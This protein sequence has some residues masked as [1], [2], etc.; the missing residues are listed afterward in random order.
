MADNENKI[1]LNVPGQANVDPSE[2][3]QESQAFKDPLSGRDTDT[4]SLAKL[5]DTRTRK[6]VKIKASSNTGPV[7]VIN[8]GSQAAVNPRVSTESGRV[9]TE[10][11]R[12]SDVLAGR[13][14]D[15]GN[16]ERMDD[17]KTRK[18][19][20]L[21]P[22]TASGPVPVIKLNTGSAPISTES[23]PISPE[24]TRTR[25]TV[26]LK[27][28]PGQ[29]VPSY[30]T[31]SA[32]LSDVLA[33]RDTDTGN[34]E[35]MDD[36]KTRKT[37]KLTP[38]TAAGTIPKVTPL[39]KPPVPGAPPQNFA[40]TVELKPVV[41]PVPGKT[42]P[43]IPTDT[44]SL[45]GVLEDTS[46]RK[47][48]KISPPPST[49]PI[50]LGTP[51]ESKPAAIPNAEAGVS[52]DTGS[53][54]GVI[55]DTATRKSVKI[56]P[57]PASAAP[58]QNFAATVELKPVVIPVPG[59]AEA[60]VSTDTGSLRGVLEDTSTRKTVKI[61][62]LPT[63]AAPPVVPAGLAQTVVSPTAPR[64]A[65]AAPD[66]APMPSRDNDDTVRLQKAKI[67]TVPPPGET[68]SPLPSV[69]QAKSVVP[70]S[71]QTI[72][73]RPSTGASTPPEEPAA[74]AIKLSPAATTSKD[75]I[76]LTPVSAA[77]SAPAP[78]APTV[79]L[80][81]SSTPP[82]APAAGAVA[83]A[84][85]VN[86]GL[87]PPAGLAPSSPTVNLSAPSAPSGLSLKKPAL[88]PAAPA[89]APKAGLSLPGKGP[90]VKPPEP[91]A[92]EEPQVIEEAAEP[93]EEAVEEK[94]AGGLQIKKR[95]ADEETQGPP[96]VQTDLEKIENGP[97]VAAGQ[98]SMLYFALAL[99]SVI[100]LLLSVY[101]TAA[102][103][104]NLWEQGRMKT[105]L[106]VPFLSEIVK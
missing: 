92:D 97:V 60:G 23:M 57:P 16:L 40:A 43:G 4:G 62:P 88:T 59:K 19:V 89:P 46:T 56:V 51:G 106:P 29:G 76:K 10:S 12:I 27:S 65:V 86:M 104:V 82:P 44:G 55:E 101:I 45:R 96:R 8:I 37:I 79:N 75:T 18:T 41:M 70:G 74:P 3:T 49:P 103:Y 26:V 9:S 91:P 99:V 94:K 54:R 25:Q 73:L 34:L 2:V 71:K 30:P 95:G 7:P 13:D 53:L 102:Q 64:P 87:K 1:V 50:T 35:R 47:T 68:A 67:P 72:K 69:A 84:P 66:A 90:S 98:P 63:P 17:T 58:P 78:S 6:T 52:T 20:K 31:E 14:T 15:T 39:A 32:P 21:A 36:T 77:A 33:G 83:S 100:C 22:L 5:D 81:G 42:A 93:E 80:T 105:K 61:S 85:T 24:D 28:A 48:V 38:L 11:A